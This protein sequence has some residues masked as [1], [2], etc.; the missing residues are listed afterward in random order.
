MSRPNPRKQLVRLT[1]EGLHLVHELRARFEQKLGRAPRPGDAWFFDAEADAAAPI[2]QHRFDAALIAAMEEAGVN[3][4][5][6]HAYRRTGML[7]TEQNVAGR[8]LDELRRWQV[9]LEEF[10]YTIVPAS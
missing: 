8:S 7:I 1:P 6:V 10:E 9:A 2:D 4:A 3:P 5:L